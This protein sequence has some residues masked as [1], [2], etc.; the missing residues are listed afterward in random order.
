MDKPW[1]NSRSPWIEQWYQLGIGGLE[2]ANG[3]GKVVKLVRGGHIA[4]MLERTTREFRAI[5]QALELWYE[6][7]GRVRYGT[8]GAPKNAG[9]QAFS[10]PHPAQRPGAGC[11]LRHSLPLSR[12]RPPP[13]SYPSQVPVKNRWQ[14]TGP[15]PGNECGWA[16]DGGGAGITG[17]IPPPAP[18]QG[19]A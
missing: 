4:G 16:P 15:P 14:Q 9:P 8:G 10:T 2:W 7:K 18:C 3:G 6:I 13:H 1:A 19:G 11:L 12:L 5:I 17:K